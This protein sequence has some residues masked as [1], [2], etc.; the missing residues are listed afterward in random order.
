M[1]IFLF[2]LILAYV[3]VLFGGGIALIW[4]GAILLKD[5]DFF[6]AFFGILLILIGI[7]LVFAGIGIIASLLAIGLKF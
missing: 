6:S 5:K 7:S 2:F 3:L 4:F 1:E